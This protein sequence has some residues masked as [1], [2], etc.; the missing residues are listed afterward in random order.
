MREKESEKARNSRRGRN[1]GE[2]ERERGRRREEGEEGR[3]E[4]RGGGRIEGIEGRGGYLL[5]WLKSMKRMSVLFLFRR[6]ISWTCTGRGR[7][8]K[9][10]RKM[11]GSSGRK[12]K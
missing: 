6:F 3:R 8:S 4:T 12:G 7:R 5:S 1:K 11:K 9:W 2:R 10:G